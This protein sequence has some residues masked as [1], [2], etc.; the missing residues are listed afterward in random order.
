MEIF[1]N[2]DELNEIFKNKFSTIFLFS[3]DGI[4]KKY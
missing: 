3:I 2:L 4:I 1:P